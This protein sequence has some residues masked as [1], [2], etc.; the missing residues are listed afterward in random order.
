MYDPDGSDAPEAARVL[1][2]AT[3]EAHGMIWSSPLYHGT[4]SGTFKNALDWL[5]L[6]ARAEPPYLTNKVIGLASVAGGVQGLQ[7]VNTMEFIVRALRGWAVPLVVPVPRAHEAFDAEG[8]VTDESVR[9]QLQGL[10]AEVVRA[11]Q[12]F[13]REGTCDYADMGARTASVEA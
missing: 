8:R 13:E 3:R 11:A 7:A 5:Q 6:L 9:E 2:E 1:A 4:V 10:G 12:Q